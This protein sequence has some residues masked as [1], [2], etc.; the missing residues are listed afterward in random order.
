M[1]EEPPAANGD[2]SRV[3]PVHTHTRTHKYNCAT[4]GGD[5]LSETETKVR[6]KTRQTQEGRKKGLKE[7][8]KKKEAFLTC[9]HL[10]RYCHSDKSRYDSP[11]QLTCREGEGGEKQSQSVPNTTR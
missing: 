10:V 9:S 8:E 11:F 6:E 1:E 5:G 3:E 4:K 2:A 7:K